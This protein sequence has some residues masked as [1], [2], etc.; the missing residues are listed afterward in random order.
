[1]SK[2]GKRVKSGAGQGGPAKWEAAL[3]AAQFEEVNWKPNITFVIGNKVEDYNWINILGETV[4]AGSRKLFSVISREAL[5]NEVRELGNPKGKKPKEVPQHYEVTESIKVLLDNNEEIPLPLLAKLLK[6]KLLWIKSNDQKRREQERKAAAD[7]GKEKKGS[8]KGKDKPKSAGKSKGGGK[9][10][11]E[12]PSAKEGSK[13]R[14]RGEEDDTG[15]YMDDEPDD[16][17]SHY[18]IVT[19]YNNPHLFGQ[20]AE[21]GINVESIIKISSQDYNRFEKK[22]DEPPIEKDE[23]T[24]ALEE[25]EM[26]VKQ[27]LKK[28]LKVF[29]KDV[30]LLLQKPSDDSKL[31]D[32]SKLDYEVK[33]LVAPQNLEDAE[34]KALFGTALYEDIACMIYDLIDSKRQHSN[35]LQNL[36]LIHVPVFGQPSPPSPGAGCP[37]TG[38]WISLRF[39]K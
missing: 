19:G 13:L 16:G 39:C 21:L 1:M 17:A 5:E 27:K 33:N 22:D 34:Q 32:I 26:K 9:K 35:Y 18:I 14:K 8:A 12:P 25:E 29:W 10:T 15:K 38:T 11:P 28:E 36:K 37:K 3:L 4:N 20:L 7:K 24:L 23:K 2:A 30:I 6:F 31:H